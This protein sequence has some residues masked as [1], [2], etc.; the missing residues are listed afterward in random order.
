M[1]DDDFDETPDAAQ[2]AME[3]DGFDNYGRWR[4]AAPAPTTTTT[5]TGGAR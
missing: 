3:Q 4:P 2:I 1:R 5:T